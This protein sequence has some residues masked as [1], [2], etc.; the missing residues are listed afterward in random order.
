[1][2][3]YSLLALIGLLAACRHHSTYQ[4]RDKWM[5]TYKMTRMTLRNRPREVT[6][7]VYAASDTVTPEKRRKFYD[8]YGFD[9]DGNTIS[10]N[11]Y[12]NDTLWIKFEYWVDQDGM[13][14]R[15][16]TMST[17]KVSTTVSRRLSDGRY[18]IINPHLT[19][20]SNATILSFL[21]G[22][23]EKIREDYSDSTA[24]GDPFQVAHFY[25]KGNRLL[26]VTGGSASGSQEV[27]YFYS[28]SD[29]PDS[30]L[31]YQGSA[32]GG[33]LLQRQLFFQ[34]AHGDVVREIVINGKDTARLEEDS[35]TYD[36]KGNWIRRVMIPRKF[37]PSNFME[38][39]I[40]VID[41]EIVY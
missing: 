23:D 20:R 36:A 21:S 2:R 16:T 19:S 3:K 40:T 17:G 1:M 41:R 31:I 13:Q 22:G 10:R 26:R 7:Y 12:M 24:H 28:H 5:L 27:V 6:Q 35:Y 11:T 33:K 30:L 14:Q 38:K 4:D 15:A 9:Q 32:N 34:N 39:E 29:A 8:R 37:D 25:C 18:M